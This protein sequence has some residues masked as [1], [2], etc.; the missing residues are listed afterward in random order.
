MH[1]PENKQDKVIL[2][3]QLWDCVK[4]KLN[5]L[6]WMYR[7]NTIRQHL[8]GANILY[9]STTWK[10]SFFEACMQ[11]CIKNE[12]V[13]GWR[14]LGLLAVQIKH[15]QGCFSECGF[16]YLKLLIQNWKTEKM[17]KIYTSGPL[18]FINK[19]FGFNNE[20]WILKQEPGRRK[21]AS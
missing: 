19:V 7:I 15:P 2:L 11:K 20:D 8:Q 6:K 16:G 17:L 4:P 1:M 3:L 12:N 5:W 14:V 9:R 21:M 10:L 13:F 18:T